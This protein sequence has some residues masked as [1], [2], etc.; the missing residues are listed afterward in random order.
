MGLLGERTTTWTQY[1]MLPSLGGMILGSELP[2]VDEVP[3]DVLGASSGPECD[4]SGHD[5]HEHS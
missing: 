3:H 2:A 4:G 1:T 5:Q